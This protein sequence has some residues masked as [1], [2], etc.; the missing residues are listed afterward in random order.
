VGDH[1]EK[2]TADSVAFPEG[3]ADTV[4]LA[5]RSVGAGKK[6]VLV[7]GFTQTGRSWEAIAAALSEDHTVVTVDL[8]GHG[9]SVDHR[10]SDLSETAAALGAAGG[11][12]DYVG[13]S[14]GGRVCLTLALER[15]ELVERLVLV[16]ATPG[17]EDDGAR[18]ERRGADEGLADRLDPP[19]GSPAAAISLETFLAEWLAGPLFSHLGPEQSGLAARL[20]NTTAGL[21]RS[22][23]TAGAGTQTPSHHRLG[24]LEMPVLLLAGARD[25]KFAMIGREMAVSIGDNATFDLLEGVG[26]AAPFEDPAGFVDRVR[27]FLD[28]GE[29]ETNR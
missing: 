4:A 16:G 21:A 2:G 9:G 6:I 27:R 17:I 14:L 13:Y 25:A 11:H 12:A 29:P 19:S 5:H 23:R 28:A 20:E 22:L 18:A 7:H 3:R 15:P 8:P 24:G 10:A 26:H 1:D